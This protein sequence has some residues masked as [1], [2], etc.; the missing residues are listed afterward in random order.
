[1][2]SERLQKLLAAAG[3]ASRRAAEE[4][5]VAG[6]VRVNGAVAEIGARADLAVDR[7]ELDGQPVGAAEASVHFAVHKPPD[8]LSSSRAERGRRSVVDLVPLGAH[9]GRL[10]PAG[11]LDADSEGLMLLTNDGAWANRVLHPRYGIEREYAVL[12]ATLPS[13]EEIDALLDGVELDDGPARL[14]A[15]ER[16]GPP[17]EVARGHGERGTWVRVRVGEGRKREVRRLFA[18]IGHRVLRL[19]RTRVGSLTLAGL[20]VGEWRELRADEVAVMAGSGAQ[21][22]A[23]RRRGRLSIAIDG[24]SG[25]GKSTIGHAVAQRIG[26]TFVDT[27]LMYRA[28]TLA[29]LDGHVDLQDGAALGTLAQRVQIA[30]RKPRPSQVGRLETVLLNRTDVTGVVRTPRVDRAVSI[31][32]AHPQVRDAMLA[33]QRAAARRGDTV[34][35]GRDIATVVLPDSTLKVFLTA[36]AAVRA[37]RRAGEMGRPDRTATYLAEIERRDAADSGRA[38]A[39]LRR[40]PDALVLDT[41]ELDVSG[42]VDAIVT[43]VPIRTQR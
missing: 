40:A 25:S 29:A 7:V 10:W 9:A 14:L 23:A 35:V 16:R 39:P 13:R 37:A 20:R 22:P 15:A 6:R 42:C 36:S 4:L 28:L 24:P 12:L 19:V 2:P 26:A 34:M 33:V 30:V 17:R 31:V 5:I 38:V 21:A 43:A 41:A 32:S 1:M 3:I 11:R 8:L 18:A 27:G